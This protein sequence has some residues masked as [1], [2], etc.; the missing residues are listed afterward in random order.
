MKQ[1]LTQFAS[2]HLWANHQL[3]DRVTALSPE[4]RTT[5]LKSSFPT[6]LS[7]VLHM[8]DAEAVWWQRMK[9]LEEIIMPGET[10]RGDW[11]DACR[12]LM[13]QSKQWQEW[14][15]NAPE[16][17]FDHEFIYQ[18]TKKEKFKQPIYQV[19]LH[20]F[21]HGTYHRGQIVNMLRQL[22]AGNIPQTDLSVYSRKRYT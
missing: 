19:A 8:W 5:P 16:H 10:F 7:T 20:V 22:D 13:N 11:D 2:Y 4:L 12:G 17:A 1:L 6:L 9:L 3:L 21:N 15:V 18:T 14:I